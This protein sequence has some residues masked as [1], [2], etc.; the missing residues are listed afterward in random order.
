MIIVDGSCTK[1]FLLVE[2]DVSFL[3][4][5]ERFLKISKNPLEAISVKT[6]QSHF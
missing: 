4:F 2:I 5:L 1:K 6:G 3:I